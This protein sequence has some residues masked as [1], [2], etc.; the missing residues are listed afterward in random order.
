MPGVANI[1]YEVSRNFENE[2]DEN[3]AFEIINSLVS[4]LIDIDSFATS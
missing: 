2:K 1:T 3:L 4:Q